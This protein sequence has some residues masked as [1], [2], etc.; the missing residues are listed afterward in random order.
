MRLKTISLC[1]RTRIC[2]LAF[3]KVTYITQ[4]YDIKSSKAEK[5]WKIQYLQS[6]P[7]SHFVHYFVTVGQHTLA[8]IPVYSSGLVAA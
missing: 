6:I 5:S 2:F 1:D 3:V 7:V 8:K 4:Y